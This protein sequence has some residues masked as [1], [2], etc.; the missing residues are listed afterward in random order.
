VRLMGGRRTVRASRSSGGF[1]EARRT[2]TKK[3][4]PSSATIVAITGAA[5]GARERCGDIFISPAIKKAGWDQTLQIR[6]EVTL[7]PGQ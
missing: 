4:A 1:V 3:H 2:D 7:A 6:R 5:G